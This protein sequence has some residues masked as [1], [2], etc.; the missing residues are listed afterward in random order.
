MRPNKENMM[1]ISLHKIKYIISSLLSAPVFTY[2]GGI[3][4][5]KTQ[6]T[7]NPREPFDPRFPKTK[8]VKLPPWAGPIEV[9]WVKDPEIDQTTDG[10]I[11]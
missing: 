7:N 1:Y 11:E 10:W 3:F 8:P 4:M 5:L 6:N 9:C 2:Q